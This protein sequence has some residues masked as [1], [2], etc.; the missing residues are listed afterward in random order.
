MGTDGY[1]LKFLKGPAE[2][3]IGRSRGK[4]YYAKK[5]DGMALDLDVNF[6]T[7]LT[8]G[9]SAA[10]PVAA[11]YS[12]SIKAYPTDANKDAA[13]KPHATSLEL[14]CGDEKN[15]LLNLHYP[16]RK[17]FRW[18]PQNCG[19]VIFKIEIGNLNLTKVYAGYQGFAKFLDDF[20]TG[21]RT[22]RPDDFPG[23]AAALKRMGITYI[24]PRYQFSGH[25][26][27][28]ELLRASPGRVPQEIASC[29]EK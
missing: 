27:V 21:Q 22:F 2:P 26:K 28:V 3:F 14:Q 25:Q 4:G 13:I 16:V 6:L 20:K 15:R 10:K 12:V 19:D 29:W 8:R 7:F 17:T 11:E 24:T 1:A 18:S 23:Q 9:A 5:V